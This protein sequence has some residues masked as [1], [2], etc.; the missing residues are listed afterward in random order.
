[1]RTI[2]LLAALACAVLATPASAATPARNGTP[3]GQAVHIVI[4]EDFISP[5]VLKKLKNSDGISVEL[6]TFTTSEER[7]ALLA[8]LKGKVDLVVADSA[9][10]GSMKQRGLVQPIDATRIPSLKHVLT[11]WQDDLGY[12]VPYLWGHTGIAWRTDKVK[13]PLKTYADLLALARQNP[14]KISL[15][16]DQHEALRAA[17][18]ANGKPPY[19]L[20]TRP[21]VAAASKLL[22]GL[23]PYV[24]FIGSELDENSPMVKGEVIA[25][26]AYN[27]DVA[28]LRDN[29]K[30]PVA[31]AIPS[32]GCMIWQEQFLMMKDAPHKDTAYRFLDA[33]ND[34]E[35]AARNANDVRY[36]TSNVLAIEHLPPEFRND[37]IIRP[38][39]N[40][41]DNCY[42]YTAVD[43]QTQAAI[44][45]VKVDN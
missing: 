18:Y 23:R 19:D 12:S 36:A 42:F 11:R 15:L 38:S 2:L 32:P 31:F 34:P 28:Y 37:A 7:D 44:E 20:K 35:L 45:A 8:K 24:R 26:Q 29:Y 9:W 17:I 13:A 33:I 1:M 22:D 6:S 14:G 5:R 43:A 30:L 25:W 39:F 41:L 10:V 16:Q 4:W 21:Q 40:G 27:G 3:T